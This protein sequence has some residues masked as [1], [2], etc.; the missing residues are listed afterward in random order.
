MAVKKAKKIRKMKRDTIFGRVRKMVQIRQQ[1]IDE[2]VEKYHVRVL[3]GNDKTGKECYTVSLIPVADCYNCKE[4]QMECYDIIN[5]C[6]RPTVM[7]SRA[8]NSAIHIADFDRFW[9]EIDQEIKAKEIEEL[10]INVGGDLNYRDF[11]KVKWLGE[12]N[13]QCDFLFFTKTYDDINKF[14][15]TTQFPVNVHPLMSAWENTPMDNPHN[16]PVSHVLYADGRTTA[17]EFGAV[18]CGGDCSECHHFKIGCWNLGKGE[19]VI[20]PAH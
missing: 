15:F 11:V 2:G 13:T 18:Y 10:R 8:V 3:P 7:L 17:P 19:H 5:D 6:W 1:I 16:L 9:A 4:C 12:E 20:F 14:L